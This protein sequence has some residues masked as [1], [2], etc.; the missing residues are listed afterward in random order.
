M[1]RG[2]RNPELQKFFSLF[3]WDTTK[4]TKLN[5]YWGMWVLSHKNCLPKLVDNQW[6][7]N[8]WNMQWHV[9]SLLHGQSFA[10][11]FQS[12]NQQDL[13]RNHK[14]VRL[15]V[16]QSLHL[17]NMAFQGW[18]P[19][20]T[21]F[22]GSHDLTMAYMRIT[23]SWFPNISNKFLHRSFELP[24][25]FQSTGKFLVHGLSTG[26]LNSTPIE[27]V[28][29]VQNIGGVLKKK[30][31]IKKTSKRWTRPWQK[32]KIGISK[33]QRPASHLE[34]GPW[35]QP[36]PWKRWPPRSAGY[37]PRLKHNWN[38]CSTSWFSARNS[39][40]GFIG[41]GEK[42][43]EKSHTNPQRSI[44]LTVIQLQ[45]SWEEAPGT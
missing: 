37:H 35:G 5:V 28:A 20:D 2:I 10:W 15:R 17:S 45:V 40:I 34:T 16:G 7:G 38:V 23:G 31:K 8:D 30:N 3:S 4:L 19:M 39:F 6:V 1:L 21:S 11:G 12:L 27:I 9:V 42:A 29:N 13:L 41:Q 36:W 14:S 25:I 24:R 26:L 44:L 33:C 22:I 43:S 32:L 18:L